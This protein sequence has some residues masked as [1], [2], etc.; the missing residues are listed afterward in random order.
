MTSPLIRKSIGAATALVIGGA[1]T[2]AVVFAQ[3]A[4]DP[5][6]GSAQTRSADTAP[7]TATPG[8]TA[9]PSASTAAATTAAPATRYKNGT[10]TATGSY[11]SP[12]GPEQ[13]GVTLTLANDTISRLSVDTS[14]ASGPAEQFQNQFA[15]G[16]DALVVGKRLDQVSVSRVSGSSLTS[17]G[18]DKAIATIAAHARR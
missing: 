14:T 12:G 5:A 9:P 2:A 7:T 18:F 10:Y 8:D 6:A 3:N 13:I 16:I 4:T 15:E 1:A 11:S 17:A